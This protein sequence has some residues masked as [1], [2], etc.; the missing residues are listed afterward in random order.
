GGL[1]VSAVDDDDDMTD[2]SSRAGILSALQEAGNDPLKTG[3][4][5]AA[6]DEQGF[7]ALVDAYAAE[8]KC[9][10]SKAM[11]ACTKAHPKAHAA[12]IDQANKGKD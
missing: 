3:K 8:N 10:K 12:Y 11:R 5:N 7:M 9:S 6:D 2:T 1:V 4:K